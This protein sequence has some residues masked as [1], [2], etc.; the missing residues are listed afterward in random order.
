MDTT[1]RRILDII[2]TEFPLVSR[3]YAHIGG[4][5]GLTQAETLA[6]VRAMQQRGIIRRIGANFQS[7][8]LGWKSTLCAAA[9]P[10]DRLEEFVAIVNSYPGVTHNYLRRHRYN[11][12]FTFIGPSWQAIEDSLEA[13]REATGVNV[14]NLPAERM[15]KIKVDFRM[16]EE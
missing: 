2:Q 9:V 14:L 16:Q 15:F 1:D 12:W 8:R 7:R 3:P 11:V 6:R 5:V 10:E 4:Q 13:I